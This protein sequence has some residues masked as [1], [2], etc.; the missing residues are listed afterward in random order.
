M[1]RLYRELYINPLFFTTGAVAVVLFVSAVMVP[2]ASFLAIAL[3]ITLIL[4]TLFDLWL[5]FRIPFQ[6]PVR[7]CADT[8]SNGDANEVRISVTNPASFA[9]T[10]YI[11]DEPPV[12]F[13]IRELSLSARLEAGA[14]TQLSYT[15][16]PSRRGRYEF[17]ACHAAF[18]SPVGILRR[19]IT[20]APEEAGSR[21]VKVYPSF[22]HLNT[23]ELMARAGHTHDSG[24]Y[25]MRTEALALEFDQIREYTQGDEVRAV[26]WA[27][28][29]RVNK[30]MV[31]KYMEER[32]QPVYALIDTGRVMEMPFDGMSLLDYSVNAALGLSRAIL[33]RHDKPGLITFS[34]EVATIVPAENRTGQ[35][36]KL[37][38][39]LYRITTDFAE[40][41]FETLYTTIRR[42]ISTRSTLLLFTNIE[43]LHSLKRALPVLQRLNKHHLLVT[44]LFKNT[45]LSELGKQTASDISDIYDIALA[46][47]AMLTKEEMLRTL[48]KSGIR[49]MTAS[50]HE[51][52]I[53]A[54]NAYLT[55]KRQRAA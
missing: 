44:I 13:Q 18:Q 19:I 34:D 41:S 53:Q 3:L 51:L 27:A 25:Q 43:T 20:A 26:N 42:D 38:E 37:T 55:L 40:S 45:E 47:E 22:H 49:A 9:L 12:E 17:G 16:T 32:A 33:S 29:A 54:I 31:N 46:E 10:C 4:F 21:R 24:S 15:I 48:R 11:T 7:R 14:S 50:P 36:R 39:A 35:H 5:L 28:S 6:K 8:F 1:M 52:S 30:L 2:A 23:Y